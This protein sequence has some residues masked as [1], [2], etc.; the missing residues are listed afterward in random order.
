MRRHIRIAGVKSWYGK[1]VVGLIL[2]PYDVIMY[3]R[4]TRI[5]IIASHEF[6]CK[7]LRAFVGVI[8]KGVTTVL[9]VPF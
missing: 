3:A 6:N 8:R 4:C 9:T 7:E 1:V 5:A 2:V